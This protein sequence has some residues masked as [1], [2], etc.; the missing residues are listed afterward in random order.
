LRFARLSPPKRAQGTG[1][2]QSFELHIPTQFVEVL[3]HVSLHRFLEV[4]VPEQPFPRK[5]RREDV[6]R[7]MCVMLLN[8]ATPT[9][10]VVAVGCGLWLGS[11]RF[12]AKR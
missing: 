6:K 11:Q 8:L 1:E 4:E 12:N 10:I 7:N 2:D 5:N 9:I 3:D